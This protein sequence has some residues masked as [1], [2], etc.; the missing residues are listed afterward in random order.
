MIR[1]GPHPKYISE[2]IKINLDRCHFCDRQA[3]FEIGRVWV[4]KEHL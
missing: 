1:A 3:R 2:Q 4:C